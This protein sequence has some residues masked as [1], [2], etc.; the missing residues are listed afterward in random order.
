ME[1]TWSIIQE[2][3]RIPAGTGHGLAGVTTTSGH[4]RRARRMLAPSV[5]PSSR[6]SPDIERTTP[7]VL[8]LGALTITGR[9]FNWGRVFCSMDAK[10]EPIL[11]CRIALSIKNQS[12]V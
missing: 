8:P 10:N 12:K 7:L 2:N 5:T 11:K 9:P 4:N 6:A 3:R 1:N